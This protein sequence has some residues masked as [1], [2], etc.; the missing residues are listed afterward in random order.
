MKALTIKGESEVELAKQQNV[1]VGEEASRVQL[2][3]EVK[4][5]SGYIGAVKKVM[6]DVDLPEID[7]IN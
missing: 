5:H 2:A 3:A 6:E 4:A 7:G 1:L